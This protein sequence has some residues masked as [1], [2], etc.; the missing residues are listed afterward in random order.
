MWGVHARFPGAAEDTSP[1][2]EGWGGGIWNSTFRSHPVRT[3]VSYIEPRQIPHSQ[4]SPKPSLQASPKPSPAHAPG[5]PH[6]H[7]SSRRRPVC[8]AFRAPFEASGP[9]EPR[10]AQQQGPQRWSCSSR[11]AEDNDMRLPCA[12]FHIHQPS[13][14]AGA[15][16]AALLRY[17]RCDPIPRR[18]QQLWHHWPWKPPRR[19]A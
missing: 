6:I 9:E 18:F 16:P 4:A 14:A 13:P 10:S 5:R 3:L 15:P 17:R 19:D 12:F 2:K 7:H 8:A 11:C 1:S